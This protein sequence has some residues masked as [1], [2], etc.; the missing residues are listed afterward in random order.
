MDVGARLGGEVMLVW[1]RFA[2]ALRAPGNKGAREQDAM[3][4]SHS[5]RRSCNNLDPVGSNP[6]PRIICF[7]Q[8]PD[9]RILW[10]AGLAIAS[11]QSL[12]YCNHGIN[13][14]TSMRLATM[15][16]AFVKQHEEILNTWLRS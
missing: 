16:A 11:L 10:S 1:S 14:V 7:E 5:D 4:L 2:T 6:A 13:D 8:R 9:I 12:P 15:D 3:N